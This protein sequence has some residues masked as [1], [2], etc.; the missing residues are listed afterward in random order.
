MMSGIITSDYTLHL[1]P[2]QFVVELMPADSYLAHEQLKEFVDG[3]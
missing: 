2:L 3:G 1:P